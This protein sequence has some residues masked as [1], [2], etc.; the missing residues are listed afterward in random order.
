M[1]IVTA[2]LGSH[3]MTVV[4]KVFVLQY[5]PTCNKKGVTLLRMVR[6]DTLLQGQSKGV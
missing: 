5:I 1:Y 4:V 6:P 3:K 2:I